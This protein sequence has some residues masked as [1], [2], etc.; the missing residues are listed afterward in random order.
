MMRGVFSGHASI[1]KLFLFVVTAVLVLT[2]VPAFAHDMTIGASRW[3]FGTSSIIANIDLNSALI[4]DIKGI[5]D[6]PYNLGASSEKQLQLVAADIIQPYIN[7][8]LSITVNDK[9]YPV[10]VSKLVRNENGLYTIWL[11]VDDIGFN[12]PVN[13][14]KIDYRLLFDE[15][16]NSHLN[17]AYLYLSDAAPDA[18]QK[19]FDYSQP[20]AQISF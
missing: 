4:A 8:R 12:K 3:C 13:A 2:A 5:I 14:V 9:E 17:L 6:G 20:T 18:V 19:V 15:T 11:N 10:K 16:N 7:K 1:T